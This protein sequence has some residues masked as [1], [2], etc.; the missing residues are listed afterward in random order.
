MMYPEYTV[1]C[2]APTGRAAKR[3]AEVTG[4]SAATVHSILQWDLESNSFGKNEDDPIQCDMLIVD[5][6][7]MVD[8]WLLYNLLKASGPVR[9]MCFIGDDHQLPSVGPG[10]V[11]R[12]MIASKTIPVCRLQYI[13][14]QK[15]G[16]EVTA[17]A[18]AVNEGNPDLS[19]YTNEVTFIDCPGSFIRNAVLDAVRG[20]MEKGYKLDDIQV[21]SPMYNGS[22]GIHVLNNA[23]QE[24][25]NPPAPAKKE[26][27][28]GYLIFREG[29]KILQ[30]K[31][32]PD[33]DVY[34]GDI[35]ILEEVED[36]RHSE[37]RQPTLYVSFQG[38]VVEYKPDT[39]DQITLAYAITVHKAQGSEYPVIIMPFSR[40][41]RYM[42][43]RKLIYTALTRA[44]R[45]LIL[46]GERDA[47][48]QG[49]RIKEYYTRQT[50]LCERLSEHAPPKKKISENR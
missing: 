4:T 21:L 42:L 16:S 10:C 29:D 12:D 37:D 34:N 11:L 2:A 3:L 49:V 27:R 8:T 43:Q 18:H 36:A 50:T 28:Y 40:Q 30:L 5:E 14:R 9:K 7:S 17:L 41:H 23:L 45:E 6:F 35:G 19:L 25:F 31:N 1:L 46:I 33:D 26:Y 13:Y 24:C 32:Q 47:F 38:N 44:R 15:N 39:M 20:E 48:E 22:A